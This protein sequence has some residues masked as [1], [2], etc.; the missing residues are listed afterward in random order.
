MKSADDDGTTLETQV[1]N[2]GADL[3]GDINVS[4][5]YQMD[6]EVEKLLQSINSRK[7]ILLIIKEA[8]NNLAKHSRSTVASLKLGIKGDNIELVI[9]DNGGGFDVDNKREGNGLKNMQSRVVELKGIMKVYSGINN[10][11]RIEI[12][13]PKSS[14]KE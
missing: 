6:P 11:T 5:T 13:I 3:L 4:F 14:F 2:F 1:K 12:L 8:I 7:N 9:K 10:G